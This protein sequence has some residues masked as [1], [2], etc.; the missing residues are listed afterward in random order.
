M[1]F[2]NILNFATFPTFIAYF[3]GQEN[4][5]NGRGDPL[6]WPRNTL[7]PQKRW[8]WFRRQAAVAQSV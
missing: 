7:Y 6:H 8:H 2:Q 1:P 5:I 3:T 4:R